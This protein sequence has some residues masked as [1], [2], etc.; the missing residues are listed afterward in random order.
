MERIKSL[1][2]AYKSTDLY[3]RIL[4]LISVA[5]SGVMF[6]TYGYIDLKSLT[7]WTMNLLDS[8]W[9]GSLYNYY[10]YCAENI[11]QMDSAYMGANYIALIPWAIWNIPVWILQRWFGVVAVGHA[12]TLLYSKLFLVLV[13]IITLVY[14]YKIANRLTG[15]NGSS[16]KAVYL[17]LSFPFAMIGIY[18][19]GQTDIISICLFVV[20]IE[21]LLKGKKIPHLVFAALS[22]G[23]KPYISIAFVAV[24]LLTEKNIWKILG[25]LIAGFS[26]PVLFHLIYYNAPMYRESISSGPSASQ[27]EAMLGITIRSQEKVFVSLFA[28]ALICVYFMVYTWR[29]DKEI[30]LIYAIVMPLV[31]YFMMAEFKFYRGIYLF[32]F[33]YILFVINKD[34][35]FWNLFMEI[36]FNIGVAIQFYCMNGRFFSNWSVFQFVRDRNPIADMMKGIGECKENI[37]M[38]Y[39]DTFYVIVTSVVFAALLLLFVINHPKWKGNMENQT[40]ISEK[41]L[42][43]IRA[44][45]PVVLILLSLY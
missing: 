19:A 27:L 10:A 14:S 40:G 43:F 23:A 8:V 37:Q 38:S 11:Y 34:R 30:Q 20:A 5:V 26:L 36:I 31:L 41:Q 45:I 29:Y 44:M 3:L 22:I 32:P 13:Q 28:V 15:E 16:L 4:F 21:K 39:D 35:M 18:Y 7:A 1:Q 12:W 42:L 9:D 33:L 6:I 25:N 24:V 2:K 17:S